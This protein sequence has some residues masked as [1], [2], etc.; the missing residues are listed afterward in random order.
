[1]VFRTSFAGRRASATVNVSNVRFVNVTIAGLPLVDAIA[2][3]SIFSISD[4][5]SAINVTVDGVLI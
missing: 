4:G 1:M 3:Q 2:D 5:D